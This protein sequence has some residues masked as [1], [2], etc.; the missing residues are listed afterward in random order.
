MK[1][2]LFNKIYKNL[3]QSQVIPQKHNTRKLI[4]YIPTN[5]HD[6]KYKG[7]KI[8]KKCLRWKNILVVSKDKCN[9]GIKR[10]NSTGNLSTITGHISYS[11]AKMRRYSLCWINLKCTIKSLKSINFIFLSF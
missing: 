8:V 11:R 5:I 9:N 2:I 1:Y 10:Q 3:P 7:N 6:K 4:N